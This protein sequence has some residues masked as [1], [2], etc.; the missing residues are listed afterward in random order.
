MRVRW[1]G[2]QSPLADEI[3]RLHAYKRALAR[4]Y[5]TEERMLRLFDRYLVEHEVTERAAITPVLLEAFLGGRP[6]HPS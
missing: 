1:R 4:R 3:A 6:R 2:F 5:H